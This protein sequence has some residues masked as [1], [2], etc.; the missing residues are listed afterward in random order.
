VIHDSSNKPRAAA[1]LALRK[2]S[3]AC[4]AVATVIERFRDDDGFVHAHGRELE[5]DAAGAR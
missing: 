1:T 3:A 4:T 5:S 2:H